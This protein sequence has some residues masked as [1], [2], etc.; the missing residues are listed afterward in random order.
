MEE[1]GPRP[2]NDRT[3]P[4]DA[5]RLLPLRGHRRHHRALARPSTS[6]DPRSTPS[7][8]PSAST[9]WS[10]G[11]SSPK[12]RPPAQ[13]TTPWP[14]FSACSA[15]GWRRPAASTSK[16]LSTERG[17]PDRHGARQGLTSWPSSRCRPESARAIDQ[18]CGERL[19]GPLLLTRDGT[20]HGP[21]RR[22]PHR[23]PTG[24]A[25]RDHEAHLAPTRSGTA[26][27]PRRST[28]ASRCGMSKSP[29]V[30]DLPIVGNV[31][32]VIPRLT[33]E[34]NE[35]A[36]SMKAKNSRRG[37]LGGDRSANGSQ[38]IRSWPKLPIEIKP[39]HLMAEIDRCREAAPLW[40]AMSAS[41]KCG[42]PS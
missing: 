17:P 42:P 37:R 4:V 31:K 9:G 1:S 7:P 21:P 33:P 26:S 5:G 2:S 40:R 3:P 23:P 30:A 11:R 15:C 32:R 41:T 22:H 24:E 8:P 19:D 35:L 6:A 38:S 13:P 16:H 18:A 36:P 39:Q 34:L 27:S 25:G 20:A 10:S 12:A 14:A 29:P 28:P